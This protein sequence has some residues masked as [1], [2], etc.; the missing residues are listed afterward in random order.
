MEF[1]KSNPVE[2]KRI[3][4]NKNKTVIKEF[5]DYM[6]DHFD[7]ED[8]DKL[9]PF[10]KSKSTLSQAT[11][12]QYINLLVSMSDNIYFREVFADV[13]GQNEVSR[14]LY[15][16]LIWNDYSI[17]TKDFCK[18]VDNKLPLPTMS[19]HYGSGSKRLTDEL[20]F[21]V[22]KV[23]EYNNRDILFLQKKY[24]EVLRFFFPVPHDYNLFAQQNIKKCD[25]TYSNEREILSF[26]KTTSEMKQ[27]K[28]I[29]FG[30]TNEKPSAKT[31][32]IIKQ[33]TSINEFYS[34]KGMD[35]LV[36][37]MLIRSYNYFNYDSQKSG[38]YN[39]KELVKLQFMDRL[40]FSI[41]RIFAMHLKG[42]RFSIYQNQQKEL[43]D[44]TK[45][46]IDN[47]P[48]DAWV[49]FDNILS[50]TYYREAYFDFE[51]EYKTYSYKFVYD[52]KLDS[53][54][55][56]P[57][58]SGK[59]T[60]DGYH[61]E[62]FHEPILK[63][64]FFYLGALGLMEL[65]YDRP[66]TPY[67]FY[68]KDKDYISVWDGLKY[69]KLTELGE[70]VF[71]FSKSYTPKEQITVPL[72]K[73]KF[74]EF[75]PIITVD[76]RNSIAI[77][78]LEPFVEKLDDSRYILS[79]SKL[80][81]NCDNSKALK[82]KIDSFYKNIEKNPPKVFVQ[83]FEKAIKNSNLMKRN[84]KQIVIELKDNKE[85]LNLFM[86]NPKLQELFI[87]AEGYRIIVL[88]DDIAKFTKI[89]KDNGFFV[90]F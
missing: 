60:V 40:P 13:L 42:I 26:G 39:L 36:A 71:G 37:D 56:D 4:I 62:L 66:I 82:L 65:K 12:E 24:S 6:Y 58:G 67:T 54:Y 76:K 45:E 23:N 21:V 80:F 51:N 86:T 70:Y 30:K 31:F 61:G 35:S 75:K 57:Y 55:D 48:K 84:L 27:N 34:Q 87:K 85:L 43:F 88:K 1:L 49:S 90:E 16:Q 11:K 59:I 73:L 2:L 41:I 20:S 7:R 14:K 32:K 28:L 53:H 47:M 8:L 46:L 63:A 69:V 50:Y 81:K 17:S 22:R 29:A 52:G 33:S 5:I 3:L 72:S 9:T 38:V 89:V 79:Y 83:F 64:V 10:M 19:L 25:F 68:A 78:K 44:L 77:A 15:A 74:D 18:S